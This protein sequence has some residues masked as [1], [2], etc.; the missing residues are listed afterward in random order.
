MNRAGPTVE[1]IYACGVR[2]RELPAPL[3]LAVLGVTGSIGSQTLD[4]VRRHPDRLQVVVVSARRRVDELEACLAELERLAPGADAPLVA[5]YDA[6]ARERAA[7]LPLAGRR[8]LA[9]GDA[10]LREAAGAA[11]ADCVVNG[12][13]GAVGL[14]PTLAA[15]RRGARIALA[16]KESLVVGGDLVRAAVHEGEAELL[17]VDS[18][19]S[20]IA[21]CL[22]GRA[23]AEVESLTLTASGGPFR[24]TPAA[25]LSAVTLA[26]VLAHPTWEMGPKITVDSATLMNKGLEVIEAHHLFGLAYDRIEVVIHPGSVVHSLV[27]FRDGAVMAQLGTPDMR[28]PLLYAISGERHWPLATERLDLRQVGALHFEDPDLER[29]PCLRLA[30]EAGRAGGRAPI[31]LNGANEVAVAGLLEGRIPY[32]AVAEVIAETLAAIPGGPVASLE[33]A[34]A[35]DADARRVAAAVIG[36]RAN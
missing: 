12:L 7:R 3:R 33:E 19:H 23:A 20:A 26:E 29:F 28:V 24:Q 32:V 36:Q 21:Q 27:T 10:G 9:A 25:G 31:V 30:R 5:V 11:D 18:E 1:P 6:E 14:V 15:A 35:V 8:L 13:V 34:L 4:L 22:A 16:N 17:P 2:R